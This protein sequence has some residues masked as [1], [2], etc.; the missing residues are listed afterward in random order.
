MVNIQNVWKR[1][2][3][4]QVLAGLNLQV[5]KGKTTVVVGRSGQGKSVLLKHIIGLIDADEGEIFVE[6]ELVNSRDE[7]SMNRI[8]RK[9]GFLFQDAALF[10]SMNVFD[11]VAFPLREHSEASE[12]EVTQRVA[13]VLGMVSLP[14]VEA[15]W[16]SELSG[17][18]RK[19]VGL[20]RALVLQPSC[21]L[22]DEPNTGLDPIT[23]SEIDQLIVDTQQRLG[24]TALVISHDMKSTQKIA[25]R[26]VMLHGG[27]II[28]EG[29]AQQF[30]ASANPAVRQF[31]DG[32]PDGPLTLTEKN[33]SHG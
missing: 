25:D 9:F 2:G 3:K 21:I 1:F 7:L 12:Y 24:I 17:G 31:L 14:G 33:E 5:E 27:R 6:G 15:K 28:E 13:E 16:P 8:R 23:S 20:A 22:Y 4:Q 30:F 19:R 26:V 32:D 10:D 18:M 29:D 11:N